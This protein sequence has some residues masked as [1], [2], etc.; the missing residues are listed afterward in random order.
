MQKKKLDFNAETQ[1]LPE[2][3]V[4]KDIDIVFQP[5]KSRRVLYVIFAEGKIKRHDHRNEHEHQKAKNKR[6]AEYITRYMF[7]PRPLFERQL[8]FIQNNSPFSSQALLL[9]IGPFAV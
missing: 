7:L 3:F 6:E 4:V 8:L 1:S 9:S 2:R 5:D